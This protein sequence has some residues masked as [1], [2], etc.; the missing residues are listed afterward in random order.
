MLHYEG[1]KLA[2]KMPCK[3]TFLTIKNCT[4]S[5]E[6]GDMEAVLDNGHC[7]CRAQTLSAAP[8][9]FAHSKFSTNQ[10]RSY[11]SDC[12]A[13]AD[14]SVRTRSFLRARQKIS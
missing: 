3:G 8:M 1:W 13:Q 11:Y 5:R 12:S 6:M 4:V 7:Y 9:M 10:N 14:D 2:T